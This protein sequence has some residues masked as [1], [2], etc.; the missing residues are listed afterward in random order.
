MVMAVGIVLLDAFIIEPN[1]TNARYEKITNEKIS[2][3]FNDYTI[4]F[5]SDLNY[6]DYTDSNRVEKIVKSINNINPDTVIFLGDLYNYTKSEA[7]ISVETQNELSNLLKQIDAKYGMFAVLGN[8]DV[9]DELLSPAQSTLQ[10]AGFQILINQ[11]VTLHSDTNNYITLTGLS[12][13]STTE[14]QTLDLSTVL[15]S[16]NFNIIIAHEPD[17]YDNL[18]SNYVDL[19]VAGHSLGGQINIPFVVDYILPDGAKK[20]YSGKYLLTNSILDVTNGIGLDYFNAR[21]NAPSELLVYK[22]NGK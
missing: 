9:S 12:S 18:D 5:F 8:Y 15:N 1:S 21:F 16:E 17:Q 13:L 2:T 14:N 19:M 4:L 22:L 6:G 3:D 10:N 7:Q 11:S 20:Y